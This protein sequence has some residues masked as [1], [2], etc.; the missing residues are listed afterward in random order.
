MALALCLRGGHVL[1][2]RRRSGPAAGLWALP[3]ARPRPG[4]GWPAACL[5]SLS[6]APDPGVDPPLR[7]LVQM[8]P[9][10]AGGPRF[11]VA[12]FRCP[13]PSRVPPGGAWHPAAD[14][15]AEGVLDTDRRFL[16]DALLPGPHAPFR[17]ALVLW[18]PGRP[19]VLR[20]G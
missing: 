8:E 11:L 14:L 7:L 10:A 13:E 1:L 20:Y 15:P 17:Q 4:E 16:A 6:P 5:R 19:R 12:V 3:A 9:A 18:G 2:A